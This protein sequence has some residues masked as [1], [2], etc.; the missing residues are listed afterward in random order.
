MDLSVSGL[1]I[2]QCYLVWLEHRDGSQIP[3]GSFTARGKGLTMELSAAV[4]GDEAVALGLSTAPGGPAVL[5]A[6]ISR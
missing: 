1:T 2:G 5:R 4:Q 6:P 3:A